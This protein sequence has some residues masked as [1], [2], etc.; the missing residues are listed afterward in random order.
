MVNIDKKIVFL[1]LEN[2]SVQENEQNIFFQ[3]V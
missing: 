1:L 3:F 2:E